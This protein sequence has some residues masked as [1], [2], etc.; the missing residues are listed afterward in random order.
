MRRFNKT[1]L[2][3]AAV[4]AIRSFTKGTLQMWLLAAV[5]I[6]WVVYMIAPLLTKR[7]PVRASK[8]KKVKKTPKPQPDK[9]E[10][11]ESVLVRQVNC[12]ITER[13]KPYYPDSNWE[14]VDANPAELVAVGGIGRIQIFDAEAY[15]FVDVVFDRRG[16][17][18]FNMV[19]IVPL[20]Q[21]AAGPNDTNCTEQPDVDVSVWYSIIGKTVLNSLIIELN[22]RGHNN[23][24]IKENGDVVVQR[25]NAEVIQTTLDN[26]PKKTRWQE[27]VQVFTQNGLTASYGDSCIAVSW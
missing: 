23:L 1:S 24:Y 6:V 18:T 7:K 4:L 3:I 11:L 19:R 10:S 14:W 13:L 25:D 17:I 9:S 21:R 12:R 2:L 5:F 15:N 22:S 26:L 8:I 20:D 27:L 16:D